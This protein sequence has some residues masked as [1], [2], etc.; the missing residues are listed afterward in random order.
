[1]NCGQICIAVK[2][3]Y[4]PESLFNPLVGAIAKLAQEVQV[5]EGID[6]KTQIGP[7]NNAMQLERV[8]GL[9]ADAKQR[10][11]KVHAGGDR[12]S[13]KGYFF[14][15]TVLT[16]LDDAAPIVAEEQFGPVLPLL[17][18]RS[19]DDA[20]ER[21]NNTSYGLGA[22]VWSSKPERAK[23][24]AKEIEAGTVWINQHVALSPHAPFGGAK[25]SGI[26]EAGGRWALA[27]FM[28]KVVINQRNS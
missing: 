4:A 18:Y 15:P 2:R 1:M 22:S 7:I 25:H 14:K 5:G 16:E 3:I 26:G 6:P 17:P 8:S 21:A 10:G 20:V 27:S 23:E 12:M 28:Q 13:R 24:I 9:V 11:A 19:V